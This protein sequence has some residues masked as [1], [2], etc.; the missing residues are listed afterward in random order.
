MASCFASCFGGSPKDHD[1][2]FP[3]DTSFHSAGGASVASFA[4]MASYRTAVSV[5]DASSPSSGKTNGNGSNRGAVS[6]A[7]AAAAAF[8]RRSTA[9]L[10]RA[11]DAAASEAQQRS[12][13]AG[14]N[15]PEA[16][17]PQE[18]ERAVEKLISVLEEREEES[19]IE[20]AEELEEV[21][22]DDAGSVAVAVAATEQAAATS[23][24]E[25]RKFGFWSRL[26]KKN[27]KAAAVEEKAAAAEE[28]DDAV[29]VAP[30]ISVSQHLAAE[31]EEAEKELELVAGEVE[32]DDDDVDGASSC[33]STPQVE[34]LEPAAAVAPHADAAVVVRTFGAELTNKEVSANAPPVASSSQ[35]PTAKPARTMSVRERA[36]AIERAA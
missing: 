7:S 10:L 25:P 35:S 14:S 19:G 16:P 6:A 1:D 15:A 30:S 12:S 29:S 2:D 34:E 21:D 13:T 36:A 3:D 23:S 17:A 11:F 24:S 26:S 20:L 22:L 8:T 9:A 31:Q 4:T 27:K 28:D 33:A 5:I 18:V 32:G